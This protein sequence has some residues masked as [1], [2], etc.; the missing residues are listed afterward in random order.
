MGKEQENT[1]LSTSAE[2]NESNTIV[3]KIPTKEKEE[4][5][6][7]TKKSRLITVFTDRSSELN[8]EGNIELTH[9]VDRLFSEFQTIIQ[10]IKP[11]PCIELN[12]RNTKD[13]IL[14]SL[15]SELIQAEQERKQLISYTKKRMEVCRPH[16]GY[17][18]ELN[19]ILSNSINTL[20]ELNENIINLSL[21]IVDRNNLIS[22]EELKAQHLID[23]LNELNTTL[24]QFL[25][26]FLV[27]NVTDKTNPDT[28]FFNE[29]LN[30]FIQNIT[31]SLNNKSLG[32]NKHA[33]AQLDSHLRRHLGIQLAGIYD[34]IAK[35]RS[36]PITEIKN[37]DTLR[38]SEK[39]Q[40]LQIEKQ[41]A[42]LILFL[43]GISASLQS[44][45]SLFIE[46]NYV[47]TNE[48]KNA[49]LTLT[50]FHQT[51]SELSILIEDYT[52][53]HK[54]ID[55][56]PSPIKRLA[57]FTSLQQ[58]TLKTI[59]ELQEKTRKQHIEAQSLFV[60]LEEHYLY[61]RSSYIKQMS[62]NL[63]Q[64]K[65]ALKIHNPQ[66]AIEEITRIENQL[67]ALKSTNER[68]T[69][70]RLHTKLKNDSKQ[71]N[72]YIYDIKSELKITWA[73]KIASHFSDKGVTHFISV[74]IAFIQL[75]SLLKDSVTPY[76]L[77][78]LSKGNPF[79]E[80]LK[81]FTD[82]SNIDLER[83]F[84][85]YSKLNN[86]TG[87]QLEY[88]IKEMSTSFNNLHESLEERDYLEQDAIVIEKR[89]QTKAYITSL[90][91]INNLD[92]EFL[93]IV[94]SHIDGA[95]TKGDGNNQL[96][97]IKEDPTQYVSQSILSKESETVL[98]QIDLRLVKLFNIRRDFQAL[99]NKYINAD[100]TLYSDE[101]Y[102]KHLFKITINHLQNDSMEDISKDVGKGSSIV[103]WIRTHVLKP[104]L[105]C[106]YV[107]KDYIDPY[108]GYLYHSR[109]VH[110]PKFFTPIHQ[111]PFGSKT[112]SQLIKTGQDALNTLESEYEG[113]LVAAAV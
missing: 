10:S 95:I 92:A 112:E 93:R 13:V 111:T 20:I 59:K 5:A 79:L 4:S 52:N 34:L 70:N 97:K 14:S 109:S 37:F 94:Y 40:N 98:N 102:I 78:N 22:P 84:K 36:I 110:T 105:Q 61:E 42:D 29:Q 8:S 107:A 27:I 23:A 101:K 100:L 35:I 60:K 80:S 2:H 28:V 3:L 67:N 53:K 24:D 21:K 1:F 54:F 11:H 18:Q 6:K 7:N 82:Q 96:A 63:Y 66:V 104:L 103:F 32:L 51:V 15:I 73:K 19:K 57:E 38:T 113:T 83:L 87:N 56:I 90:S 44:E 75:H 43:E 86:S 71:L 26:T 88:W 49:Q 17:M 76:R 9:Q 39:E 33:I 89:M 55:R 58:M 45:L 85:T 50:A 65:C 25:L 69:L 30:G 16:V 41:H 12:E 48:F 77:P 74:H 91:I 68:P 106:H 64:T 47:N 62:D 72:E 99:N 108:L 81:N 46:S 31:E